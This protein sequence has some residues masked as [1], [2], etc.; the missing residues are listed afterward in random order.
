VC[1][2]RRYYICPCAGLGTMF[3]F[4]GLTV[5]LGESLNPI[6]RVAQ[7]LEGLSDKVEADGKKEEKLYDNYVCWFKTVESQITQS[8][9]AANN[10]IKA[11]EAYIDDIANGREEFT[12]EREDLAKEIGELQNQLEEEKATR[13]Q[14]RKEFQDLEAESTAAISALGDAINVLGDA[15]ADSKEGVLLG[16][17][18]ALRKKLVS[19]ASDQLEYAESANYVE[20][21]IAK[22]LQTPTNKEWDKLD[23][24]ST[25]FNKKYKGRSFK[26]QKI[27]AEMKGT[28]E[29]NLEKSRKDE[30]QAEE[31]YNALR[32]RK[33][34][35]LS[36]RR[37]AAASLK[38][39]NAARAKARA[40]SEQERD[41]LEAQVESDKKSLGEAKE[42]FAKK[43]EEYAERVRL[44]TEEVASIAEAIGVLR[45]DDARDTFKNSFDSQTPDFL[46]T[47][48]QSTKCTTKRNEKALKIL[49]ENG[50]ARLRVLALFAASKVDTTKFPD[51][52]I[53]KIDSILAD[54][55][56]EADDDE[57]EKN[58]C[59]KLRATKANEAKEHS[60]SIDDNTEEIGRQ[61]ALVQKFTNEIKEKNERVEQ[62]KSDIQEAN[63]QRAS[64]RKEHAIAKADDEEAVRLI[65]KAIAALSKFYEDNQLALVQVHKSTDSPVKVAGQAPAPPPATWDEEYGGQKEANE[66]V[67]AILELIKG[68]VQKDIR[69]ADEEEQ[70]AQT[71]H[72]EFVEKS[73]NGPGG[74]S[75]LESQVDNLKT[76]RAES[77]KTIDS[78]SSERTA[79]KEVLAGTIDAIQAAEPECNFITTKFSVRKSNRAAEVDGLEKAK[80]V[81]KGAK[82]GFLEC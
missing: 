50:N 63:E 14:A 12:T 57:R 23:E 3:R 79:S 51:N 68:D 39:E 69:V 54:L 47:T 34:A 9:E 76:Q 75:A 44:R 43:K 33:K 70:K 65:D 24:K 13:D 58:E 82:F 66:G 1:S 42:S 18:S 8:N 32:D 26:I 61:T 11:L 77:N 4:I 29:T 64:E 22:E 28:F 41:D 19:S 7:L 21:L 15:T 59:E 81:L 48:S 25:T 38:A 56:T 52:V 36:N 6:T 2:E 16:V 46:Q 27:L 45:S 62:I 17:R 80:A 40:E 60:N 73:R 10:R 30:R 55:R 49:A 78:E 37:D 31:D 71:A 5:A 53:T 74:I 72:D 67:T 20:S 35:T